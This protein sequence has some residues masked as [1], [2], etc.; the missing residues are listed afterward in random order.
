VCILGAQTRGAIAGTVTDQ[1]GASLKGAQ[2]TMQSPALTTA[3][4][5]Q[6]RYYI[7]DLAAGTYKLSVSYVGL[8]PFTTSV[9]VN[10]GQ[11]ATL[12]AKLQIA[13]RD[14][15]VVVSAR[16]PS[17][18]AE[19]IN[20]ERSADNLLQVMPHEVIESLPN[21]NLADAIGRLPSVTARAR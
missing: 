16:R 13:N 17:A 8:A 10:P 6:G 19:A 5:E 4:N 20:E 1:T 9:T 2:V 18:E 14:E 3:T 7:N 11:T 21:A 15:S 12:D